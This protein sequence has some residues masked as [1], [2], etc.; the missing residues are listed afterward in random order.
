[1]LISHDETT[2][3]A[4]PTS[5]YM[6]RKLF[7]I[8]DQIIKYATCQKCCKLYSI[9]D[10]PADKPHHCSFQNYPNHPMTNFRILC[11]NAITKQVPT[12]QGI[13]YRP[14]LIYPIVNIKHQ[15]KRLYSKKGFEESCRKW[16]ARPNNNQEQCVKFMCTM[17]TC[18]HFFWSVHNFINLMCTIVHKNYFD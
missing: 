8:G 7:G 3:S 17:C 2:Y 15:L 6:A 16:A 9:K 18:A 5:L 4:F 13:L 12:N 11:G 1:M 14:L 10:L